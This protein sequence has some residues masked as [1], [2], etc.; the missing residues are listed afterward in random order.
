M[1]NTRQIRL[2]SFVVAV[3]I[4]S[5]IIGYRA[6][7]VNQ[8]IKEVR[9]SLHELATSQNLMK[10]KR[11]EIKKRIEFLRLGM[12]T[13]RIHPIE[14]PKPSRERYTELNAKE[15]RSHDEDLELNRLRDIAESA[16]DGIHPDYL[17]W[18]LE[19]EKA[20]A[21]RLILDN[22]IAVHNAKIAETHLH[23]RERQRRFWRDVFIWWDT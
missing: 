13:A 23:L 19:V 6:F 11:A 5:A 3:V 15:N 20:E 7:L 22:L 12:N 2:A 10:T 18:Q 1:K 4:S 14:I 16:V 8:N 9:N 21:D 17:S